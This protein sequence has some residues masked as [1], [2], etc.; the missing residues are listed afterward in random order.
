[1]VVSASPH[2]TN[3]GKCEFRRMLTVVHKPVGQV[4]GAPTGVLLQSLARIRSCITLVPGK[5]RKGFGSSFLDM[6]IKK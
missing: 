3:I 4:S 6:A 1:M 2:H 5:N